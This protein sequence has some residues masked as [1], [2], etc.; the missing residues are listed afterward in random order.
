MPDSCFSM[1]VSLAAVLILSSSVAGKSAASQEA[2]RAED[3]PPVY[4]G[5]S[6]RVRGVFVT[7]VA[8][9]PFEATVLINSK[10]SL[11][12][13]TVETQQTMNTIARDSRGRIHNERRRLEPEGFHGTPPLIETHIF[14]PQ[15][16]LNTFYEAGSR[17]ARQSVLPALPRNP[18]LATGGLR[19]TP[20][21]KEEDLGTTTLNGMTA[22]GLRRTHVINA[23]ASGTGKPVEVVDEYWYS[24]DLHVNLLVHHS[25]PR[26]GE[27]TVAVSGIKRGEPEAALFEV[28]AGFKTVDV[29]PPA[30]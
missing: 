14:E 20:S 18:G 4:G 9:A 13:G 25:D 1:K 6:L 24:E 11:P 19:Q 29:T 22:Q 7:P 26:T 10:H 12:D 5:A 21:L 28:P 3:Q 27:Q 2:L 8:G 23:Q 15:T 17:V 30:R 16:R